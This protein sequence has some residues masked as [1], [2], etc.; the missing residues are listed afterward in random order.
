M[1]KLMFML[2]LTAIFAAG[3]GTV[4][5][6]AWDDSATGTSDLAIYI[7]EGDLATGST[8]AAITDAS[9]ALT[10]VAGAA[11]SGALVATDDFYGEGETGTF[12]AGTRSFYAILFDGATVAAS[13]NYQV[14]GPESTDVPG[15]GFSSLEFDLTGLTSSGWK[16]ISGG[17]TDVPEPTSGLLLL[18]GGA[19]LALRRKR[20]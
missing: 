6:S 20:G 17:T 2:T 16:S 4:K 3:A 11:D 1:K 14:F 5:W 15:S 19:M 18:V 13:T 7:M 12:A 8:I 9:S 10:Y